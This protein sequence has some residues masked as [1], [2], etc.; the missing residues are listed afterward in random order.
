M[1]S[2]EQITRALVAIFETSRGHTTLAHYRAQC[3][4]TLGKTFGR[5]TIVGSLDAYAETILACDD[6]GKVYSLSF[7][8][9]TPLGEALFVEQDTEESLR[10]IAAN[11]P[12]AA[13]AVLGERIGAF[14]GVESVERSKS[15]AGELVDLAYQLTLAMEVVLER[16]ESYREAD[17]MA[18]D[19]RA[20]T[21]LLATVSH[22]IRTPLSAIINLPERIRAEFTFDEKQNSSRFVGSSTVALRSLDMLERSGQHLLNLVNDILDVDRIESGEMPLRPELS[23]VTS[24]LEQV[25]E[26]CEAFAEQRD[27]RIELV[28]SA[29]LG[30]L[31]CDPIRFVQILVNLVTNGIKY[32]DPGGSVSLSA[33]A[34]DPDHIEISV[35]DRGIGIS[36]QDQEKI[37]SR[38]MRLHPADGSETNP[39]G[40]GLGLHITRKLVELHDGSISVDSEV[41]RGS[42]F[43]VLLPRHARSLDL[44]RGRNELPATAD[45]VNGSHH[46]ILLIDDDATVLETAELLLEELGHNIV[47]ST[48]I[49][50]IDQLIQ[51]LDPSLLVLDVSIAGVN[52]LDVLR[53]LRKEHDPDSL[54]VLISSG[55][56]IDPRELT[57][58]GAGWLPKP[59]RRVDLLSAVS[60]E[61]KR[62]TLKS[63]ILG[64]DSNQRHQGSI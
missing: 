31:L 64:T 39:D 37:F 57:G 23:D 34:I 5:R 21:E 14:I 4:A 13:S 63:N 52:G 2:H 55:H 33:R 40:T 26:S 44:L 54:P 12:I 48:D 58:L 1:L 38:Y 11:G 29:G 42:T 50:R 28:D 15:G 59:W 46:T 49:R 16:A 22:E 35:A 7:D 47:S 43:T 32:S 51:E 17:A 8:A 61:L 18:Q 24:L 20:K 41:G 45:T 19:A 53:R 25:T 10:V 36:I 56:S 60:H 27:I 30:D 9:S 6:R 3:A 62:N